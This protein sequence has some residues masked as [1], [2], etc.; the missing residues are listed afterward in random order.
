VRLTSRVLCPHCSAVLDARLM[1]GRP[2][3][4]PATPP[5]GAF[6]LCVY[7]LRIGVYAPDGLL[8]KPTAEE[9]RRADVS[10][11]IQ[12]SLRE[13]RVMHRARADAGNPVRAP[14]I[15]GEGSRAP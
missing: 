7:C 3:E 12:A 6:G 5:A 4:V 13:L 1:V 2:G 8:R 14:R 11:V 10:D 15:V 9:Q